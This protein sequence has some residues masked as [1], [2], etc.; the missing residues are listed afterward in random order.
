MLGIEPRVEVSVDSFQ[1]LP[2]LVAGTRRIALVQERLAKRLAPI[3]DVRVVEAPYET[4]PLREGLW[5]HPVHTHDG[6]H[7]WLRDL[8]ARVGAGLPHPPVR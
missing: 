5:W 6:A 8:A 1:L 7:I 2:F 3:A 4:V